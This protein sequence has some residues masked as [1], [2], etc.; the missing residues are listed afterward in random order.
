MNED[1]RAVEHRRS[2]LAAATVTKIFLE[3]LRE[4]PAK[5]TRHLLLQQLDR[6]G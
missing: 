2:F 6:W 4:L 5:K 1:L 3:H